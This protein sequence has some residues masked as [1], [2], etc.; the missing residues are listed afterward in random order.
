MWRILSPCYGGL[1]EKCVVSVSFVPFLS[2]AWLDYDLLFCN[3]FC[4]SCMLREMI[5][6]AGVVS[7]AEIMKFL[8]S[9]CVQIIRML[10]LL[11][12]K[13]SVKTDE[14]LVVFGRFCL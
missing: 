7:S 5:L 14:I 6:F 1:L 2:S 11:K 3:D 4:V 12:R 13:M 8:G 9:F 10:V